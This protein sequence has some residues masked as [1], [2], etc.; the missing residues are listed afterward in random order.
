MR[1]YNTVI[2]ATV[3]MLLNMVIVFHMVNGLGKSR[4]RAPHGAS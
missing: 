1:V 2:L 4:S 3:V